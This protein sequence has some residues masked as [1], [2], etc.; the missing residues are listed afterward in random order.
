M[1][2]VDEKVMVW[3]YQPRAIDR[4]GSHDPRSAAVQARPKRSR[5]SYVVSVSTVSA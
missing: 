2:L 3:Q 4:S 5:R 1:M